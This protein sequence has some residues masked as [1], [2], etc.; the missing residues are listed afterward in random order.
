MKKILPLLLLLSLTSCNKTPEV[1]V[2]TS[3]F[4]IQQ[5]NDR[6]TI[7]EDEIV[8]PFNTSISLSVYSYSGTYSKSIY[9]DMDNDFKYFTEYYHALADRHYHYSKDGVRINNLKV[10]NESYGKNEWIKVDSFLYELLK[11]NY[12]FSILT[13]GRF[14]M[15]LGC[16]NEIYENRNNQTTL[17]YVFSKASGFTFSSFTDYEKEKIDEYSL[18]MPS[19]DDIKGLLSFDDSTS[20][21]RFNTLYKKDKKIEELEISLA[22]SAKG[23]ATE[24]IGNYFKDKYN[25]I[26]LILNSGHSSIKAIGIRPDNKNWR[27][28]FENPLYYLYKLDSTKYKE[29]EIKINYEREFSLSTS[30]NYL[31]SFYEY[32]NGTIKRRDHVINPYTGYSLNYLDSV[33]LFIDD[34][35]LADMM[36]TTLLTSKDNDDFVSLISLFTKEYNLTNFKYFYSYESIKGSKYNLSISDFDYLSDLNLPISILN[37]DSIYTGDYKDISLSDIKSVKTSF[38]KDIQMSYFVSESLY[39]STSGDNINKIG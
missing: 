9:D 33:S 10:I 11:K 24:I 12:E 15:F 31:Q 27:I 8:S 3:P 18:Y 17:D 1:K 38:N 2:F 13:N 5:E 7:N 32:E 25:G 14:N 34:A 29:C 37:D 39:T 4:Y 23:Y 36:T 20:S 19:K 21:V 26:S 30:G 16:I 35:L 6:I 28:N 22:S